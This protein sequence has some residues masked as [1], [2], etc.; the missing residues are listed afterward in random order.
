MDK[1]L[2]KIEQELLKELR[3]RKIAPKEM[4]IVLKSLRGVNPKK[5]IPKKIDFPDNHIKF[6]AFSDAHMGHKDYR[7][8]V[9]MKMILD[10]KKQGIEFW[11]NA[12]DT[13]EGMS[14]REGHIYELDYLG[15]SAQMDFFVNQFKRFRIPI[16]S[17]EAQGS[18]SGWYKNKGN[19]GLNI[20]EEMERRSKHY[21]FIGYDEQDIILDNGLKIRLRHPGGGTAYAISYKM[22]KHILSMSGG[23]K[24]HVLIQG[25][26]HKMNHMFYRNIHGFD[27]GCLCD[28]TPFMKKLDTPAHVGYWIL[29]VNMYRNKKRGVERVDS[30]FVPFYE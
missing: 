18:H 19:M 27:A 30:Q 21:K 16:Y 22:Q 17:I 2:T 28:Q 4:A 7:P 10:G 29:D 25:H 5:Y 23:K 6:G 20:G 24:P 1:K 11:V 26:F 3:K 13:M 14:G 12:G 9:L 15:Y 8:D